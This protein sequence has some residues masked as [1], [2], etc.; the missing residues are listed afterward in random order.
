MS[1]L[2]NIT[3][4]QLEPLSFPLH[5]MRLIEASAGTGKTFTIAGLYLRLLL[6]HGDQFSAHKTPLTVEQ[7]LVV[8]FTEAA[9]AELRDRIRAR[10]HQARIAFSRGES[11]DP[12]IQPLLNQTPDHGL[13]CQLLLD[14]ER[15]MDEA[16]IFTIH[17]FCQ[18][19]LTQNAFESGSRF[20]SELIT[21]ESELMKQAVADYWRRQFYPLPQALVDAVR[22]QWRSPEI[23]LKEI[24]TH[25]SGSERY[26]YA[27]GG[28]NNLTEQY[29]DRLIKTQQMKSQWLEA[30]SQVEKIIAD[31]GIAKNPYNKR[32]V[33]NWISKLD[34]WAEQQSNS[35]TFP[36]ELERFRCSVLQDKTK[37]GA[38]PQLEAF[39]QIEVFLQLPAIDIKQSILVDAIE[40]CRQ[41]VIKSKQKKHQLSF[42]DLLSHLNTA[43]LNDTTELLRERIRSLYPV[44][45]IDEFQDT[46]PQQYS[47]FSQVY[48][49][50]AECGLFMIGDPKQAIYA[51]RGADI[52]TYIQARKEVTSHFNLTTNW[53]SSA[54]MVE[55]SNLL[56]SEAIQPFIYDDDIP[57]IAVDPSPKAHSM[58]WQVEGEPQP[59][60]TTWLMDS[61]QG[62]KKADYLEVMAQGCA[63]EIGRLLT[64]SQ[65]GQATVAGQ[66]IKPNNIAVLV[67]TGNEAAMVRQALSKKGIASVYLSN[68]D[69]VYASAAAPD[70]AMFLYAVLNN[71]D[72]GAIRASLG[73]QLLQLPLSYLD[74]LQ[75]DESQWESVVNEFTDYK[76]YLDKFGVMALIRYWIQKRTLAQ[77]L[78]SQL[79][80]ERLLTD[81][82]HLAEVLQ[83][84]SVE[85]ESEYALLRWFNERIENA[86]SG[87]GSEE[88]KQRLES[89]QNLIQVVTIHKSKGLEYDLVFVPFVSGFRA[90][91]QAIYYDAELKQSRL[92]LDNNKQGIKQAE[93][94][95]LAEDLRLLYVAITRAVY[96]CYMGIAAL[97]DGNKKALSTHQSAIGYLLQGAEP[98]EASVLSHCLNELESKFACMRVCEPPQWDDSQVV[99]SHQSQQ[100]VVAAQLKHTIDTEWRM[101]SY[102]GL[103]KAGKH[104]YTP[105][106]LLS[107]D[108][109]IDAAQDQAMP[110][111]VLER[112][113]F[114]FPRGANPGTFLHTL[115]EQ[116]EYTETAF[117][118]LNQA[119]IE[120]LLHD[121]QLDSEWLP[122]LQSMVNTVLD[123]DLDG[124]GLKLNRLQ[125][126]QRLVEME[127]L[128]PIKHLS[129]Q[130]F[131]Q[132][133]SDNDSLTAQAQA[134]EFNRVKGMLKGFIDLVF[135][136]EGK[137][138]VLDWKSNHLGD[139]ASLYHSQSLQQ[140]MLE[141]RYDAQYQIYALALH[142]FLKSR[143]LDYDY[144]THFG[145][146]YYLFLRGMDGSGDYGVFNTK[147][148]QALLEQ[149]DMHIKGEVK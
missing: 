45:M 96:G 114:N 16:A 132:I 61:E 22:E 130:V 10:I 56:F 73:C 65:R 97:K 27:P 43:L 101:T 60:L 70:L 109:D 55:A 91:K 75:Q 116:V 54:D 95:R 26:I 36:A 104:S 15:Q 40:T 25:L 81:L 146:V 82:M 57:F 20:A 115:F 23:L 87:D 52:F 44:A 93:Q 140:A 6:G 32:N 4:K 105:S 29:Q 80:G 37:K 66:S 102:S 110:N 49:G 137:F 112:N 19:M 85:L 51:F 122:I 86:N 76:Q 34:S 127:F 24:K 144:Q 89:E 125:P 94:E 147:P 118:E 9:T 14:A 111:I 136:H 78:K 41:S 72:E 58:Q 106:S 63:T 134:L 124:K 113:M 7:I 50:H 107:G 12:V 108:I 99:T 135:E 30:S 83:Q 84:A 77:T 1:Q 62:V 31:S 67:R 42:D 100:Q 141:H 13:A 68:R 8:T 123:T 120:K 133:A 103:S 33:P 128:L 28:V 48:Q 46:D 2:S 142:R 121:E 98:Q 59:A 143:I 149:L 129:A 17:G 38:P 145:G 21:D 126:K 3:V 90:S 148:N 35:I 92:D 5:G 139:D 53:R 18:R 71:H 119:I 47:I 39:D 117:S 88:Q 138:Y 11:N 69:S 74:A 131:H 79:E 64:A